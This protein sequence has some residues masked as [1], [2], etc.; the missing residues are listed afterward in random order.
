M[1]I[2]RNYIHLKSYYKQKSE[3]FDF[4]I[5]YLEVSGE[6]DEALLSV[7]FIVNTCT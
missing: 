1:I 6:Q 2:L 7:E 4:H 3:H 5:Y